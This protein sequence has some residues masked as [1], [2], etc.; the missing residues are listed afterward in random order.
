MAHKHRLI[1]V[2]GVN[3]ALIYHNEKTT[4]IERFNTFLSGSS[5]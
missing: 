3:Q 5:D 1:V 2:V 4:C